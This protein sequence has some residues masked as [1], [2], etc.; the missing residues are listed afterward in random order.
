M[1]RLKATR[2]WPI[3]I[4]FLPVTGYLV[5]VI[6]FN[7]VSFLGFAPQIGYTVNKGLRF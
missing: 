5:F 4:S 3:Q 6:P 7:R 1:E 2:K